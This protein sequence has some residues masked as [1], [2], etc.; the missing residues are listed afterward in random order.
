VFAGTVA[1]AQAVYRI[2]AAYDAA[3]PW[4]RPPAA[5]PGGLPP[6]LRVGVPDAGSRRFGGDPLSAEAFDKAIADLRRALGTVAFVAVDL[7]P[8]FA[9]GDL[10]YDGPWIAERYEALRALIEQNP[11][12]LHPTTRQI[13]SGAAGYS[14]A[15]AFAGFYR[16]AEL[17]RVTD[18]VWSRI[19][20][21]AVPA[22]PRP[23]M[24]A[25]FEADAIGPNTE[26]GTY[27]NFVNLLDLCA[28]AVPGRFRA[29]GLASGV[30]LIAPAGQDGLLGA[31]GAPFHAA[32]DPGIGATGARVPAAPCASHRAGPGEI[33]LAV[34]GAHLSGLPLNHEL[35]TRRARFLRALDTAPVYRLYALPGEPPHRAGLLRTAPG[36][37]VAVATEVWALPPQGFG[38]FVAAIPPPLVIGTLRLADGT[39]PKG[40]LVEVEGI[41]GAADISGF[42]GW[43]AYL[44]SLA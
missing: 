37:G 1:D 26:L 24:L 11:G 39:A 5:A 43:R 28:L 14:A 21:L 38:T 17:R 2:M 19:D 15:D 30:T 29:D 31:L 22:I 41:R 9:A 42:G 8:F 23:R 3:D 16:L 12:A 44:K 4:S 7:T 13:I 6:G 20:V 25:D 27:T 33:E 35:T 10:L 36:E 34:A 40:L 18:E 32:A